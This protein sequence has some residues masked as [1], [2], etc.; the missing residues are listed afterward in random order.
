MALALT[1]CVDAS[2]LQS[3]SVDNTCP[4]RGCLWPQ[5]VVPFTRLH[6]SLMYC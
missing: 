5:N 3:K 6:F 2:Y 1:A 4:E